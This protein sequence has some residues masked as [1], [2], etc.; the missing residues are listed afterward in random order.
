NRY[1]KGGE[2]AYLNCPMDEDEYNAFI[3][4]LMAGEKV[5]PKNFEKE[6]FF[7]G[8]QPIEAIASTG[9]E[10]LRFGAM[11]PVGLTDPVTGRRAHAIV[12]LRPENRARTAY[13]L[14]GFQTK[15]K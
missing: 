10:S 6:K 14:V 11:K 15:L 12:Q 2:E 1:D 13:N 9:R 4:A 5:L 8:C 7:Q 3:D